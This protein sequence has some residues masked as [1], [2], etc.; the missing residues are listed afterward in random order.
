MGEYHPRACAGTVLTTDEPAHAQRA[1]DEPAQAQRAQAV[2]VQQGLAS[3]LD[4][5][6]AELGLEA[7]AL[8][9]LREKLEED[10]AEPEYI[11]TVRGV[12]YRFRDR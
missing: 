9:K 10:P 5:V 6:K 7:P 4:D 1:T 3:K 2:Y 11:L 12:G 8:R